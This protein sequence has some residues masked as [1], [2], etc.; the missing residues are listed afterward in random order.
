[1]KQDE[2]I[3]TQFTVHDDRR[4]ITFEYLLHHN[5]QT[6]TFSESLTFPTALK[7]TPE[8]Q[9]SL[10]ALHLALGI[11]YYKIFV[12]PVITHPYAMD[13]AEA[14]FWNNVW[15]NGLGEFL[16]VN[17]LSAD[18]LARFAAQSGQQYEGETD[19]TCVRGALL[20]IGGGKDSIV[21]G[22][23]LKD[24]NVPVAG[25]VMA[26]GEALGQAGAVADTMSVPLHAIE[27]RLDTQVSEL[28]RQPGAYRG[29]VP[30]SLIFALVGTA[31]ATATDSAYVVVANEAS[32]SIPHTTWNNYAVN[33][34]W[35]KSFEA[36]QA[37]Q[38]YVQHYI[39][40][41]VTYFSAIRSLTSIAVAKLFAHYPQY[42][43]V[44]T[45][46]NTVF[47]IDPARRP[48]GRWSLDSP[49]S[50]SSYILLAPWLSD[51]DVARVFTIDFLNEASLA[52]L[53]LELTG[54]EGHPPLDCV[55]TPE[56]L[57][58]SINM[59]ARDGRYHDTAL[60]KL[61]AERAVIHDA[62]WDAELHKLLKLQPDE[63]VPEELQNSIK[64]QLQER[65]S[66]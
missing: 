10:R 9:R 13:D 59:L 55:G 39:N 53:F 4:T 27:R 19:T 46:D 24:S 12:P 45:S 65:V 22:E 48:S 7:D 23:L 33:H 42:F 32:A 38:K 56:E 21:A 20:G 51:S 37:I 43:E 57:T 41:Q 40:S 36:E 25:F 58:V 47:R 35:S 63:A 60:M 18:M 34:Q 31:L 1:M 17:Q 8:Q 61:A 2:F 50:L 29:H 64:T 15:R 28:G 11:S 14:V 54:V 30:I 3:Y 52:Q 26:T 44:F 66:K 5:D 16:Y 62:D 49:K 6:H